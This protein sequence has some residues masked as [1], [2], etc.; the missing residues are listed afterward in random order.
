VRR[1]SALLAIAFGLVAA[2]ARAQDVDYEKAKLPNGMTVILHEDH[3]LPVGAVNIWY[4][5]GSKDEPVRRSGFAH[6]F[7]HLMFMGTKRAPTGEFDKI[8]S[9]GG[10]SNNATTNEDRTNYFEHGPAP[11][12]PTLLWLEADRLEDLGAAMTQEKLDRQRDIVRNERRQTHENRPYGKAELVLQGLMYPE[13]HPYHIPVIGTHEDLEAATVQDVKDFFASH[14][15]PNNASIVIAGDFDPEKVKPL[16]MKLFGTLPRGNDPPHR[17]AAP[18]K[19]AQSIRDTVVDKVQLPRITFAYHSPARLTDGDAEMD[20]A[21]SVLSQGKTSRLYRKLVYEERLCTQVRASQGSM[22]LGS[23]FQVDLTPRPGADL[24][25]VEKIADEEIAK[26][27][28]QGPTSEELER[29]KAELELSMLTRLQSVERVADKLNE[30]EYYWGEPNSFKRDLDR[31]RN[32]TPDRVRA[33]AREVL[34]APRVV[35]RVLPEDPRHTEAGR[36]ERPTKEEAKAFE[37]SAPET[38]KLSNGMQL[39]VFPRPTL[40]LVSAELLFQP[41]SAI[42]TD[43]E[44]KRAGLASLTA[45]MLKEGAGDLDAL[46]FDEM[47]QSLGARLSTGAGHEQAT[48]SLTVLRRN[49]EKAASL[50]AD[51]VRRPRFDAKEW[52]RTKRLH[53]EGLRRR[54]DNPTNVAQNVAQRLGYGDHHPF[55]WPIDGTPASVGALQ[56]NDVKAEHG[57]V[58]RPEVCTILV[59]GD[60]TTAEV[61]AT[62]EKLLGDW[63]PSANGNVKSEPLGGR[64]K[65][66]KLRVVVVDRPDAVQTVIRLELPGPTYGTPNRIPL[67]MFNAVFG[68]GFSSRLNQ[69]LRE[70]HGYTYG[71]SSRFSFEPNT[72]SFVASSSVRA[73]VT[74]ASLK[75]MLGEI[76]KIREG[77]SIQ[78]PETSRAREQL[79]ADA[80]HAT[81]D[82]AGL[83]GVMGEFVR[84]NVGWDEWKKDVARIES[85]KTAELNALAHD[86]IPLEQGVLVLVGDKKLVL[87]QLKGLGIPE[88]VEVDSRGEVFDKK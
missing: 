20:L 2:P 3:T 6:L 22:Q 36:D 45:A 54:D 70:A 38:A 42:H 28:D 67:R 65:Q 83:L 39:I 66:D 24:D 80:V 72:G 18:V 50:M 84:N 16:V 25:K 48:V 58:F 51:A 59:A 52:E 57:V 33:R 71:A 69:N 64:P 31:Y 17:T 13:G 88:P 60:V 85:V 7:E 46:K 35:L 12:L 30:Y 76:A 44:G 34:S 77:S 40:P 41:G 79:H 19:L 21:A 73:D 55:A 14:Y 75:E 87:E 27:L 32:A 47:L 63:T 82:L 15:V 4:G 61:K 11:L 81:G 37:P 74:G 5:V 43:S 56:L 1:H 78:D 9:G 86:A 10:G 8:L 68:G 23:M 26:F 29:R 53:L 49:F 62:F